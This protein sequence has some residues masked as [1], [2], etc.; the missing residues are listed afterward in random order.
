M[1]KYVLTLL[2]GTFVLSMS[3][4]ANPVVEI[5]NVAAQEKVQVEAPVQKKFQKVRDDF[6]NK[7]KLTEEQKKKADEI[8]QN[9][10]GEMDEIHAQMKEL[11]KKADAIREKNKKEFESLLTQEQKDTLKSMTDKHKSGKNRRKWMKKPQPIEME[12]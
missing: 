2:A 12:K 3:A 7:L 5:Q 8:Y 10:R 6:A 11:R 9:S 1:K 4:F